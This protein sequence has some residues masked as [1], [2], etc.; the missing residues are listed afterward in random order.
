MEMERDKRR[1]NSEL[2]RRARLVSGISLPSRVLGQ[3]P[4]PPVTLGD[5]LYHPHLVDKEAEALREGWDWDS[6]P[7]LLSF[8]VW[9]FNNQRL[10]VDYFTQKTKAL[11]L[12]APGS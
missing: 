4:P 2:L 9:S 11:A 10:P 1:R 12:Q 5:W 8:R 6:S 7:S 3:P